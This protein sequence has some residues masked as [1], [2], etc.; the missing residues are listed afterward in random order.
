MTQPIH[1]SFGS[2]SRSVIRVMLMTVLVV[3]VAACRPQLPEGVMSEGRM[4]RILFDYHMAQGVAE[5]TTPDTGNVETYRY[6]LI[7]AV[8]RKHGITE[9]EFEASMTYY[10]SDLQRLNKIY[11]RLERRF[12][13]E[14]NAF[15]TTHIQDVY[16][17]LSAYGDT[18]NVW[19]GRPLMVIRSTVQENIHTWM[20]SCDSTWLPGDEVIW[21][22]MPLSFSSRN[23]RSLTADLVI[24]YTNDSVR[25]A[26]RHGTPRTQMEIRVA[27]PEGWTPQTII[28]HLYTSVSR[29]QQDLAVLAATNVM[30]IR[31]HM[32]QPEKP[33]ALPGDT[34]ATDTL[35]VDSVEEKAQGNNDR[36]L[37]PE[38]FRRQQNVDQ[39]IDIVK[40]KPYVRPQQRGRR[41]IQQ[42]HLVPQRQQ[43][44]R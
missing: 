20:Q 1:T 10:C 43:Q 30:L 36:R 15:G 6:E 7:Q 8:F 4:E 37:S 18:A 17:D 13:R 2:S 22:F 33:E 16:A 21:R 42:P 44:R 39:K 31:L 28:G 34:L 3:L 5:Q 19:G 35:A 29:E 14:A 9:E 40:E 32:Q 25:S 24:R 12:E 23:F 26:F 38:E 11:R 41:R 27:N